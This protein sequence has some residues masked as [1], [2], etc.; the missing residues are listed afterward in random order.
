MR[1]TGG[2]A[3]LSQ[4]SPS[5]SARR[6]GRG[7]RVSSVF[8]QDGVAFQAKEAKTKLMNLDTGA[9]RLITWKDYL[10]TVLNKN[11]KSQLCT[12]DSKNSLR[13]DAVGTVGNISDVKY[14]SDATTDLIS[15]SKLGEIGFRVSFEDEEGPVVIRRKS[16]NAIECIG[17]KENGLYWITE[18]QFLYL[19]HVD[20]DLGINKAHLDN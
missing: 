16:N 7:G 5:S 12:A 18:E 6:G 20:L 9:N 2:G 1:Q 11:V 17:T 4:G 8:Q 13:V 14:C 19:A 15:I 10:F 3:N